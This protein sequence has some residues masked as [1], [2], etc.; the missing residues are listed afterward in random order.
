[1]IYLR[2]STDPKSLTSFLIRKFTWSAFSHV[3]VCLP[4]GLLGA[5]TSG[6][7]QLRKLNYDAHA[8]YAYYRIKPG[9]LSPLQEANLVAW[10]KDQIGKPYDYS[11][12]FGSA[13]HHDWTHPGQ[14]F[15]SEMV[16]AGFKMVGAPLL[17]VDFLDRVTPRDLSISPYVQPWTAPPF[18]STN[19]PAGIV[20]I[21]SAAA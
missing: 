13:L 21:S 11:A 5:H 19:C 3:D 10:L 9:L 20:K 4:G 15:C 7:V 1:M 17:N 18:Y 6:G 14:W 16:A 8:Q 2:F 12:V